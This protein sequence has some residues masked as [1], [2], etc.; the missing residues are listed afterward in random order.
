MLPIFT[1]L[2]DRIEQADSAT[3]SAIGIFEQLSVERFPHTAENLGVL[4]RFELTHAEAGRAVDA[5]IG[6][7]DEAGHRNH[8][9]QRRR[10]LPAIADERPPLWDFALNLT[11]VTFEAPGRFSVVIRVDKVVV[12]EIP[13]R[14]SVRARPE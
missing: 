9:D 3:F 6:V 11:G 4:A 10:R 12:A 5:N 1:L 14:V 7:V 8:L 2:A 13:I